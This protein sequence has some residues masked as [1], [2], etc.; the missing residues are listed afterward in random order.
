M[1]ALTNIRL[2]TLYVTLSSSACEC[3]GVGA[4]RNMSCDSYGGQCSCSEPAE[5]L[6]SYIGRQC[7]LCPFYSYQTPDGCTGAYTCVHNY[8]VGLYL[9]MYVQVI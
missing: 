4:D 8:I 6:D 1:F 5:G 7:D 3:G 9:L 2:N